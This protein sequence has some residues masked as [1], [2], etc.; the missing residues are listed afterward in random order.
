MKLTRDDYQRASD[1]GVSAA[2]LSKRMRLGW[3]LECAITQVPKAVPLITPE[4]NQ[5]KQRAVAN[6]ISLSTFNW[7]V[8]AGW[9]MQ[10]AATTPVRAWERSYL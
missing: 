1:Y 3:N 9:E 4:L 2:L 10:K 7:R 6:S 5:W 8:R